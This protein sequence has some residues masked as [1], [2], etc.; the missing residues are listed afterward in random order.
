M[1]VVGL[2]LGAARIGVA[3]SD[4]AGV[5]ASPHSVVRR[6]G[7]HAADHRA[8]AAVIEE[9]EAELLVVGLPRSLDG[10]LG[11]AATSALTEVDELAAAVDV[12]V[13][14]VDERLTTVS[15]ERTLRDLHV[16]GAARR[17]V[18]DKVAAAILLQAWLDGAAAR[19]G[20]GGRG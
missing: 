18:V 8:V 6:T 4:P 10:S 12:P 15:D 7:S 13:T 1:R 9:Y 5:V 20:G 19:E 14:T 16:K 3:V 11:A 17:A 2:D